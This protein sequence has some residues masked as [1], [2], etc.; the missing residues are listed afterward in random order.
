MKQTTAFIVTVA[1]L[2]LKLCCV[3][4]YGI[5]VLYQRERNDVLEEVM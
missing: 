4:V 2:V 5:G 3:L 1:E